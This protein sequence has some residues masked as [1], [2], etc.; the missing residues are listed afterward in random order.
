MN[1]IRLS[2]WM[3]ALIAF[4]CGTPERRYDYEDKAEVKNRFMAAVKECYRDRKDGVLHE[5]VIGAE[6]VRIAFQYDKEM[7]GSDTEFIELSF[8]HAAAAQGSG[9]NAPSRRVYSVRVF[10][11][12]RGRDKTLA[13]MTEMVEVKMRAK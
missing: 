10:Q 3:C 13:A 2:G 9:A 11:P 12:R 8:G 7:D 1:V 5:P 6:D 4:G